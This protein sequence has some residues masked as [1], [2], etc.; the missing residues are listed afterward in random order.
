[1]N[2]MM[3]FNLIL[4]LLFGTAG[5]VVAYIAHGFLNNS[6]RAVVLQ[7]AELMMASAEAVREYTATNLEP[8]LRQK[9]FHPESV[10]NF[11]A[12]T[13]FKLM[14]QRYPE[15]IYKE[16]ALN[17]RNLEHRASDWEADII[18]WL[19][20]HPKD[21]EVIGERDAATG[22]VLYV[23][24]PIKADMECM[25]CHST[26]DAAPPSMVTR[27]G[28]A[29]GFGWNF[30]DTIGAEIVTVPMAVPIQIANQA[31]RGLLIY[32]FVTLAVTMIALDGAVY[33]F[34]IRPLAVI[35]DTANRVSKGEK[36]VPPLLVTGKD[37]IAKVTA[38]FNRMQTSL[39]KALKMLD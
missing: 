21:A 3:R 27:Y 32:L 25:V 31:F 30:G 4:L 13:T 39:A 28:N 15:Y 18:G 12:I 26:A 16:T 29:N 10:P 11:G 7:Q 6:A 35:S 33:W 2:L 5:V 37:E 17:P 1:M 22:R 34:V 23:A 19:R 20:E 24:R 14:K 8:L 38:A 9:E 36:N